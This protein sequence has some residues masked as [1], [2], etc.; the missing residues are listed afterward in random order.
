MFRALTFVARF[1]FGTTAISLAAL[2]AGHLPGESIR[3]TM[4]DATF[5]VDSAGDGSDSAPGDGA[6]AVAPDGPC[7]LRAAIQEANAIPGRDTIAFDLE[8]PRRIAPTTPLPPLTD[9]VVIDGNTQ[10]GF[11][12]TPIIEL[13]GSLAGPATGLV[14]GG[15]DSVVRGLV[16]NR[17]SGGIWVR[18]DG[19]VV[20]GNLIGTDVT[21]RYDRGNRGDGVFLSNGAGNLIGGTER[22][23]RNIISGNDQYGVEI[24]AGGNRVQGN[25]IGTNITGERPIGNRFNGVVSSGFCPSPTIIGGPEHRAGNVISGNGTRGI[26]TEGNCA[27]IQGNKIGTDVTGRRPLG[28][29]TEGIGITDYSEVRENVIANNGDYGLVG[30]WGVALGNS[31]HSNAN[32]GLDLWGTE[33]TPPIIEEAGRARG[34]VTVKGS[35]HLTAPAAVPTN[36]E[37]ELFANKACD[38]SGFGEGQLPLGS[39]IVATNSV[40]DASFS[41]TVD[42][43]T[44]SFQYVTA[45]LTTTSYPTG[46]SVTSNFSNCLPIALP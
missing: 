25:F 21:G 29:G 26:L 23:A 18:S 44:R 14:L 4:A 20:Q 9:A 22:L 42:A 19:N 30:A 3:T 35:A 15:G 43:P 12:R 39:V 31:I 40:G 17:F 36:L 10:P 32:V 11:R 28:N 8:R 45:T 46:L 1:A 6:C 33:L 7:T 24:L 13:D 2:L 5:T 37:I 34:A 38:P 41:I 16:I 27:L